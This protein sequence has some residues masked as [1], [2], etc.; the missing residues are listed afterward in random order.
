MPVESVSVRPS[1]AVMWLS[2]AL[3]LLLGVLGLFLWAAHRQAVQNATLTTSNLVQVIE[4]SLSNDFGRIEG[5]LAFVER[6]VAAQHRLQDAGGDEGAHIRFVLQ[7]LEGSFEK[8]AALNVFDADGRLQASSRP[9]DGSVEIGDLA[10][11]RALREDPTAKVA[12]SVV[13][14]AS[15]TGRHS[16]A[17]AYAMR[18]AYGRFRGVVGAVMDIDAV[19]E[20]FRGIDVGEGGVALLRR[21]DDLTLLQRYPPLNEADFNQP[22][23][24]KIRSASAFRVASAAVPC[25]I[26][27]VPTAWSASAAFG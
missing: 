3:L 23:P 17:M 9:I 27:P 12:F 10:H 1:S 15:T 6:E 8:I 16:L 7:R 19:G 13:R 20:L 5:L 2:A 11:F 18:D 14:V 26:P 25:V 24:P 4:S 21:S 22:L